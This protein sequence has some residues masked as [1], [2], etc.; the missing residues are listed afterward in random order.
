MLEP[1]RSATREIVEHVA[2]PTYDELMLEDVSTPYPFE[3]SFDDVKNTNVMGLHTS[4]TS[5][6]P[7]PI[8][9]NHS[10][11]STIPS[12][13]DPTIK[14]GNGNDLNLMRELFL[15][16]DILVPFPL[17]HVRSFIVAMNY[18]SLLLTC[19]AVWWYGFVTMQSIL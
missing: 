1:L 2:S 16:Q 13:L 3:K 5:G 7:K 18:G 4:G 9:W 11:L 8:R 10:A 6:H 14:Y 12:F 17:Y 15:G 19:V